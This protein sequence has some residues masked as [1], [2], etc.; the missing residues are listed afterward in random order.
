MHKAK[1]AKKCDGLPLAYPDRE[2]VVRSSPICS[3]MR[4]LFLV[5]DALN[6]TMSKPSSLHTRDTVVVL[7][8]NVHGIY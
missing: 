1:H 7:P 4:V 2:V 5:S 8:K 3:L 6:S